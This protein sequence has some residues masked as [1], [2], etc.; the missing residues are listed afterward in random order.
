MRMSSPEESMIDRRNFSEK[1]H[2][3]LFSLAANL[4]SG[5]TPS[6]ESTTEAVVPGAE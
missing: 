3:C 1:S 5:W 6:K 2:S 4:T